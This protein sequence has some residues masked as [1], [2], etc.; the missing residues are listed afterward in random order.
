L[1]ESKGK[2]QVGIWKVGP[3]GVTRAFAAGGLIS[4]PGEG[5]DVV[6]ELRGDRPSGDIAAINFAS[7]KGCRT[8]AAAIVAAEL[9]ESAGDDQRR[10]K[11]NSESSQSFR[12][13]IG[14]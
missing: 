10:E 13:P 1:L 3:P 5:E 11:N 9:R 4:D 8:A 12:S 2:I 7:V 6:R 14:Y